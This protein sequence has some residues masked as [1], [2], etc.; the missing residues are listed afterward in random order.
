MRGRAG[1][2]ALVGAAAGIVAAALFTVL[3]STGSTSR[4]PGSDT[5]AV[6]SERTDALLEELID[7][8][9]ALRRTVANETRVTPPSRR[10]PEAEPPRAVAA[11]SAAPLME[12]PLTGRTRHVPTDA[13]KDADWAALKVLQKFEKDESVRRAWLLTEEAE[14]E[15]RFGFP[16]AVSESGR[17]WHYIRRRSDGAQLEY[18]YLNFDDLGRLASIYYRNKQR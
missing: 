5:P 16:T 14:I 6:N 17:Q 4:A 9:R 8:V 1:V 15:R 18:Y 11:P 3:M 13:R 10:A 12:T 2:S 7:E